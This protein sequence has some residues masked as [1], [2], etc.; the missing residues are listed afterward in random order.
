MKKRQR[1]RFPR[2]D[3]L[4]GGAAAGEEPRGDPSYGNDCP[5]CSDGFF[6][7]SFLVRFPHSSSHVLSL[8]PSKLS[9]IL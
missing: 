9:F 1:A 5:A 7:F 8:L 4:C 3:G 2:A 6:F